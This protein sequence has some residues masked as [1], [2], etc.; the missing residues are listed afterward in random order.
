[1]V[2]AVNNRQAARNKFGLGKNF[3]KLNTKRIEERG[4]SNE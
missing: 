3:P 1:L 4:V 2:A